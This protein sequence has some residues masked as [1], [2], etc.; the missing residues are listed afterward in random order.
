M[1]DASIQDICYVGNL[2]VIGEIIEM[3]GAIASIQ[4]YEETSGIGPGEPVESTGQALSVELGPGIVSQMYDGI[5]RPL[6]VFAEQTKSNFLS[7][8]VKISPLDHEKKWAFQPTVSTA[9]KVIAGDILGTVEETALITHKIMVPPGI[10]GNVIEISNGAFTLDECIAIIATATGK[11]EIT[12][13]QKWPIR[14]LRPVQEKRNPDLPMITGQ[15][16]IDTFFPVAKGG[17]AAVPGS[18]GAGKTVVQYQIAKW[19]D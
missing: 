18:F 7:R 17:A 1:S 11:K 16:V 8:G 2:G 15:R 6:D 19:A 10:S 14:K 9:S 12:M 4:V 3:R 5:Q 13:L